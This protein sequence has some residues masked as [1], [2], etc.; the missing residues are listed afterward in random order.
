MPCLSERK[1]EKSMQSKMGEGFH[2]VLIY[3]ELATYFDEVTF[4]SIFIKEINCNVRL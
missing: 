2:H 4:L 1:L 3:R